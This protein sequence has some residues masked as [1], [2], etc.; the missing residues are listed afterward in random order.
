MEGDDLVGLISR[1]DLMTALDIVKQSGSFERSGEP[2]F[3]T[4]RT[5]QPN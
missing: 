2:E 1:T 4:D 5:E 3:G